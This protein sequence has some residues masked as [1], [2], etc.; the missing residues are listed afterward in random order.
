MRAS[1][2]VCSVKS[3]HFCV[4]LLVI[5]LFTGVGLRCES[6]QIFLTLKTHQQWKAKIL[7]CHSLSPGLNI[8][9]GE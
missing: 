7:S 8:G 5:F 6:K 1:L 3:H 2:S 9:V 4:T